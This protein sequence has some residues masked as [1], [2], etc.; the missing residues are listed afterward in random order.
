MDIS[1]IHKKY[2]LVEMIMAKRES[3]LWSTCFNEKHVSDVPVMTARSSTGDRCRDPQADA[4]AGIL[5]H[6]LV[7]WQSGRLV[8]DPALQPVVVL[9]QRLHFIL[10]TLIQLKQIISL[11]TKHLFKGH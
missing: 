1:E 5:L 9:F 7:K 4:E 6:R 3:I 10:I 11:I 2:K 8:I